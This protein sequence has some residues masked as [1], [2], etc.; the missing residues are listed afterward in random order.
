MV[1]ISAPPEDPVDAP[2]H[3]FVDGLDAIIWEGDPQHN[4]T[5]FVSRRTEDLLGYPSE[6]WLN[7]PE[8]WTR[9][10]HPEDRDR[11]LTEVRSGTLDGKRA[12]SEHR[13]ITAT[14]RTLWVRNLWQEMRLPDGTRRVR[15]MAIDITEQRE[16]EEALRHSEDRI[17]KVFDSSH[18]PILILDPKLD[19]IVDCNPRACELLGYTRSELVALRL[20]TLHVDD[21]VEGQELHKCVLPSRQGETHERIWK[22]RSGELVP[23][24]VSASV[25][26][27]GGRPVILAIVR[28][29]RERKRL[30]QEQ[31]IL[32]EASAI[33]ASSLDFE[34]NLD[35]VVRLIVPAVADGCAV[36]L[37][38]RRGPPR[39]IAAH[40]DPQ[41]LD[42][43]RRSPA[44]HSSRVRPTLRANSI[45]VPIAIRRQT[46]G[47]LRLTT[48]ISGRRFAQGDLRLAR[49]LAH[50]CAHAI[51]NAELYLQTQQAVRVRDEFLASTSH[52]LRTP[53]HHIKAFVSSLRLPDVEWDEATRED[54]L[55]EIEREADRLGRLIA[56]L[57]DLSRVE[58]GGMDLTQR[59][60]RTPADLVRGGLDRLRTLL[61]GWTLLV[62]IPSDLPFV[63]S[64]VAQ[65]EGVIANLV[66]NATKYARP[67][68]TIRIFARLAGQNIDIV[69]EDDGPGIA[70]EHLES[71]FE[72]FFRVRDPMQPGIPGTGLGLAICR[73]VVGAHGGRIWAENRAEGGARF[74]VRLPVVEAERITTRQ[75][76]VAKAVQSRS[77]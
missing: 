59:E 77:R 69:V 73:A 54:F 21:R 49:E 17:R 2:F 4:L 5:R 40:A 3:D 39:R 16:A 71:I 53:L 36:D 67:K 9:I 51:E 28:D 19:Q 75:R 26:D 58:S 48:D 23:T 47:I 27:L 6:R 65:L 22:A 72:K 18:D 11:V 15:G 14:G 43:F 1:P 35:R 70:V 41:R 45:V 76:K 31:T 38:R 32:A 68:S 29:I 7:E 13:L 66:E 74:V 30:H 57:L 52:E 63:S 55:T 62:E 44:T 42:R 12:V 24:E 34:I 8:F 61:D 64:D 50:R 56:D 37:V 60:L 10:V 25:L 46:L 20:S 33:L